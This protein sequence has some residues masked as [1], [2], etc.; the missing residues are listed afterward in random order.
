MTMASYLQTAAR[1]PEEMLDGFLER[2][3][4]QY[5]LAGFASVC[6]GMA[7][8]R[9]TGHV[10]LPVI[11][12]AALI[13]TLTAVRPKLYAVLLPMLFLI[14]F[15][16][17]PTLRT[18]AVPP[19]ALV[20]LPSGILAAFVLS[21]RRRVP[22][23]VLDYCVFAF[24]GSAL[25]SGLATG[26]GLRLAQSLAETTLVAYLAYRLTFTC[27]PEMH[28]RLATVIVLVGAAL[29]CFG[30]W[31]VVHGSSPLTHS[32]LNNPD[33]AQ[34]TTPLLRNGTLRAAATLGHPLA[35]GS[36]LIV[37]LVIAFAH[38]R[39]VLLALIGA[40]IVCTF[41]RGPYIAAI[42]SIFLYA[43]C[44]RRIGRLTALAAVLT[45][46]ALF[47]GPVRHAVTA[48]VVGGQSGAA[49]ALYRSQ[50]LQTSLSGATLWGNPAP[51][52][53][54][55]YG[56]AG[57]FQL[58]DVASQ[59]A[60]MVGRQGI[61]GLTVWI[62][63]LLGILY[64]VRVGVRRG[65]SLLVA[66]GVALVGEWIS[67]VTVSLITSFEYAF[68][69]IL[70]LVAARL[71][72][73]GPLSAATDSDADPPSARRFAPPPPAGR[74]RPDLRAAMQLRSTDRRAFGASVPPRDGF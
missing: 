18:G 50:L 16:W 25:I 1:L 13:A 61:I 14:P 68:L 36:F 12:G 45:L 65:D 40:G 10:W 59:I 17:S 15:T 20:I 24:V 52:A 34:W 55:L 37:P 6:V 21:T 11:A 67:L 51:K 9:H 62:T 8:T 44:T 73:H 22:L 38:R 7:L 41:S 31:E 43:L 33:L 28:Q 53:S 30:I 39:W 29:S 2:P 74:A 48:S 63:L 58:S 71:S 72:D 42:A 23:N 69:M 57:Q 70:G 26:S 47:V 4:A 46:F 19:V 66:C 64:A 54:A 3:W 49:N 32:A 60:L 27:W 35:F 5:L 56:H